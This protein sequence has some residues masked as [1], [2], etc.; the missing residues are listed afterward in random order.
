MG[1]IRD[2]FEELRESGD[3]VRISVTLETEDGKNWTVVEQT[4]AVRFHPEKFE[5][6]RQMGLIFED[7]VF[8]L[9]LDDVYRRN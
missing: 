1:M 6:G 3:N 2:K 5:S 8:H 4:D 9:D 7:I